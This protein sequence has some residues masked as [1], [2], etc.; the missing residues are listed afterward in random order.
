V[1]SDPNGSDA[2]LLPSFCASSAN[3]GATILG[4]HANPK[5]MGASALDVAGLKG[6]FAH[7]RFPLLQ[8]F[9]V[10]RQVKIRP[11]FKCVCSFCGCFFGLTR[12]QKRRV[13]KSNGDKPSFTCK[14]TSILI[15]EEH[16]C[17]IIS[18]RST[19]QV[20]YCQ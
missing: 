8:I 18:Q 10:K 12:P 6:H 16:F 7:N 13:G 20:F 14:K 3:N 9:V 17:Q 1:Y 15:I 4:F 11:L 19:F 5:S 2:Q